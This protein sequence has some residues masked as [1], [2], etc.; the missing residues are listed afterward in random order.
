VNAYGAIISRRKSRFR[1]S[2]NWDLASLAYEIG[3]KLA[4]KCKML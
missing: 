4:V 1:Y 2:D 3:K